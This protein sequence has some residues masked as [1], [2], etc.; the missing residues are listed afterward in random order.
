MCIYRMTISIISAN[1]AGVTY[2]CYIRYIRTA[3]N[4][5]HTKLLTIP[6][7]WPL[8]TRPSQI[9]GLFLRYFSEALI[10][11]KPPEVIKTGLRVLPS[12]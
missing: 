8:C 4:S 10:F 3:L 12:D 2:G 11:I 5:N 1:D 7:G 6:S 9:P